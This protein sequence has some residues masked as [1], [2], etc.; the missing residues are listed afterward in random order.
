MKRN[1]LR[2]LLAGCLLSFTL[3]LVSEPVVA[4]AS[5]ASRYQLAEESNYQ[6]GCF[7]PCMCPILLNETL[8]GSFVLDLISRDGEFDVYEVREIDWQ[9][10]QGEDTIHVSGTGLYLIG[11]QTQSMALDLKVGDAAIQHFESGIVP[12]QVEF[13]AI[14]IAAAVNGFFCYDFVFAIAAMPAPVN[15]DNETWG[16]LKSIYR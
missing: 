9:F 3:W 2:P 6:E 10:R 13:P 15:V 5:A 16:S 1:M 14:S 8:A 11:R 12:L 7:D 4:W